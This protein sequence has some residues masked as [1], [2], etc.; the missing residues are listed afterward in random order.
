MRAP[1]AQRVDRGREVGD[2]HDAGHRL[3]H[4]A[5]HFATGPHR[6]LG[7]QLPT[8]RGEA[9]DGLAQRE[10]AGEREGEDVHLVGDRRAADVLERRLRAERDALHA[11]GNEQRLHHQQADA[12]LLVGKRGEQ[13][14]RYAGLAGKGVD[15]RAHRHLQLLGVEVLLEHLQLAAH[16]GLAHGPVERGDRLQ[17]ELLQPLPHQHVGEHVLEAG[18]IVRLQEREHV[19]FERGRELVA[20]RHGTRVGKRVQLVQRVRHQLAGTHA[21]VHQALDRAQLRDVR[22]RVLTL[23]VVVPPRL[24]KPVAALPHPQHILGQT[25]LALHGADVEHES[26]SFER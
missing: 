5:G 16:P 11:L 8:Q 4:T 20:A 15:R 21:H 25:G 19:P 26:R 22:G 1:A 2:Q 14:A 7:R 10:R 6:H 9:V 17:H 23:A 18:C 3:A 13:H 24:G 12:V